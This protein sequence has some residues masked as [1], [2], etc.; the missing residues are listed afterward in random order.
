[1][2]FGV[3]VSKACVEDGEDVLQGYGH[4]EVVESESYG[5]GGGRVVVRGWG[6]VAGSVSTQLA[7]RPLARLTVM[8]AVVGRGLGL[9]H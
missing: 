4:A 1:M 2:E 5:V 6:K 9:C 7:I 3:D 8:R